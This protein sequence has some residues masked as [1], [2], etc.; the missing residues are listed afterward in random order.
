MMKMKMPLW[1]GDTNKGEV[2]KTY[3]QYTE[4]FDE[5]QAERIFN[6]DFGIVVIG[7]IA[8]IVLALLG[9]I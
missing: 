7:A 6:R 2:K 3:N 1:C 4:E 5:C 8:V 9:V